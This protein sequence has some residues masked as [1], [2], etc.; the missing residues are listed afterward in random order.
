MNQEEIANL[1][2]DLI[3][4]TSIGGGEVSV[5]HEETKEV[6]KKD[7]KTKSAWFSVDIKSPDLLLGR[8]GE[9]LFALNHLVRKII[10][11]KHFKNANTD[12]LP[13]ELEIIIDING[14]QK[15]RIENIHALVHMMAERARYFK[16]SIEIDPMPAFERRVVHEF[17]ADATD[18][19]T[20]SS[21]EGSNRRVVIKYI[22]EI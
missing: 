12:S 3:E 7:G 17:L 14:Y 6:I 13:E 1:I 21:G 11:A 19:K 2:K 10:E 22:G 16:S 20:E 8:D 15:K 5:T 9:A 18:L 4:K